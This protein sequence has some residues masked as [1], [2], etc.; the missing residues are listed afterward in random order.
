MAFILINL[1]DKLKSKDKKI[2]YLVYSLLL[3]CIFS[4][5][6]FIYISYSTFS[7]LALSNYLNLNTTIL[8]SLL[9]PLIVFSYLLHKTNDFSYVI[10]ELGL[11]RDK[12]TLKNII[13]GIVL[14]L[15]ILIF[16][17]FGITIFSRLTNIALPTHV[18]QLLQGFPLY[19][20]LFIFLV[21]PINEEIMFRGFLVSRIGIIP[22]AIIFA[23]LHFSY[24]SI[25]E[26][27]AAL[28]FG[29][30]AGYALKRTKSL[31]V[32]IIAHMIL[33]FLT[34]LVLFLI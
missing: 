17:E 6:Y 27:V 28:I 8:I 21:A 24:A 18:Q 31:Y 30:L 13:Y 15:I 29:L 3:I 33:N 25:A 22:S 10:K 23:L 7:Q 2:K 11:S 19:F 26:F 20:Y 14:F 34:I 32:S 4:L 5:L 9:F 1:E 16:V 12:L